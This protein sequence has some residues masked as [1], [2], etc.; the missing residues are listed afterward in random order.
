MSCDYRWPLLN[1]NEE[2][3]ANLTSHACRFDLD[4]ED[5]HQC[6]CGA[7]PEDA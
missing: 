4:H 6:V 7:R 3:Q 1:P 2:D 5:G